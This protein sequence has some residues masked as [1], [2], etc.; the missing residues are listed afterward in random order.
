MVKSIIK[1]YTETGKVEYQYRGGIFTE[2]Y[3]AI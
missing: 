2:N 1:K 3:G